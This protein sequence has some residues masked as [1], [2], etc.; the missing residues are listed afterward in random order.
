MQ[1]H[2]NSYKVTEKRNLMHYSRIAYTLLFSILSIAAANGQNPLPVV[3]KG[4]AT[5]A[6]AACSD[7]FAGNVNFA[8]FIGQSNDIW[9]TGAPSPDTIFLCADDHFDLAITGQNLTGDPDMST[10]AGVGYALYNCPPTISGPDK[11]TVG[12]DCHYMGATDFLVSTGGVTTGIQTFTNTGNLQGLLNSG[13]PVCVWF[14]PIT[15]DALNGNT[16]VY[17]NGGP[18]VNVNVSDAFP[19]VYL[20]QIQISDIQNT[21]G[22]FGC[23]GSFIV[24]GGLPEYISGEHYQIDISLVSDPS[25]KAILLKDSYSDGDLVR[26]QVNTAGLYNIRVRDGKSCDATATV[27]MPG[28]PTISLDLPDTTGQQ[29]TKICVPLTA[30]NFT[31]INGL[32]FTINWDSTVL[33][34][35]NIT[36]SLPDFDVSSYNQLNGGQVVVVWLTFSGVNIPDGDPVMEICFDLTGPPGGSTPIWLGPN[37]NGIAISDINGNQYGLL[38]KPGSIAIVNPNALSV[39]LDST[40]ALCAGDAT[41]SIDITV[42]AGAAFPISVDYDNNGGNP[43]GTVNITT[44]GQ[45]TTINNLTAGTYNLHFTDNNGGVLDTTIQV[46]D[47][48]TL[49][50]GLPTPTGTGL[51]YGESMQICPIVSVNGTQVNDLSGYS[52]VWSNGHTTQCIDTVPNGFFAVTVTDPDGC[53]ASASGVLTQKPPIVLNTTITQPTCSGVSNGVIDVQFSGGTSATGDYS[54]QWQHLPGSNMAASSQIFNLAPGT[55]YITVTDDDGCTASDSFTLAYEKEISLMATAQS[56]SCYGSQDG[57]ITASAH[58]IGGTE[59]LPYTF[60]WSPAVTNTSNPNPND[61]VA[62]DL[63][64]GTY[65]I[66]VSDADGCVDTTTAEVTEPDSITIVLDSIRHE[67]CGTGGDGLIAITATGGAGGITYAWN[68]TPPQNTNIIGGLAS[69]TYTVTVTDINGCTR[70]TNF[71]VNPPTPPVITGFNKTDVTCPT[72][73]DGTM[74]PVVTPGNGTNLSFSWNQG[75]NTPSISGLQTG[76]YSVTIADEY[77]CTA[78]ASDS[79]VATDG[80]FIASDT[81]IRPTCPGFAD[82]S[83]ILTVAGSG[84]YS[85]NWD[86]GTSTTNTLSG[87]TAGTYNVTVVD[88]Q[89][90]CPPLTGTYTLPD[91]PHIVPVTT[92]IQGASCYDGSFLDGSAQTTA[93]YSDST[94]GTFTFT[95]QP[96]FYQCQNTDNCTVT[97]LGPGQAILTVDDGTCSV[98]DTI[99]VPAP[100]SIKIDYTTTPAS[101]YHSTDGGATAIATG[102]T[103]GTNPDYTYSWTPGGQ[104]GPNLT[105]VPAGNYTVSVTDGVGCSATFDIVIDEPDSLE[106]LVDLTKTVDVYCYGDSTGQIV[107]QA[108]GGNG[109]YSFDWSPDISNTNIASL[110]PAGDYSV[111]VTDQKGCTQ[112][113]D[114]TLSQNEP[115]VASLNPVEPPECFGYQT[116]ISIDTVYGGAGGPYTYSVDYS[117][118][119]SIELEYQVFADSHYVLVYDAFECSTA[120][121]VNITEPEEIFLNLPEVVTVELGDSVQL[122]PIYSSQLP[123]DSFYWTPTNYLSDSSL[124]Q[125]FVVGLDQD[126]VFELTLVDANG[127]TQTAAVQVELDRNRNVY[128]PNVFSPNHDGFNDVFF[129]K[130]GIGVKEVNFMNIYDRWGELIYSAE[131]FLP[132]DNS[133]QYWDGTFRGKALHPGVFVYLIQV[134]F[135]DG[136]KLLYRG[137]VT[138]IR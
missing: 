84:N 79:I 119:Q 60:T 114:Y 75:Q 4:P 129:P 65:Q 76:I 73:N 33:S 106:L 93:A 61:E 3:S 107:V 27:N 52:F 23:K 117:P 121:S 98:N 88:N 48:K 15:F 11:A 94:S 132:R 45:M 78:T 118:P 58:N 2:L 92:L 83:I 9:N 20:N 86:T 71:T 110:L 36:S 89:S 12:G 8:N 26:F 95:W 14:A 49:G 53:Q 74:E 105:N 40:A 62:S 29:G 25:V 69:G 32:E 113:L 77:G 70:E 96:N 115:I 68:T 1:E 80:F 10:P 21:I 31:D 50:A 46:L 123:I 72:D 43:M 128:I 41:G 24:Q 6:R 56:I 64:A 91:P 44:A 99:I 39:T 97:N 136:R 18:C 22:G 5:A 120:L 34:F 102:G 90:A 19:V 87:V 59:A 122:I 82:G 127:C 55:Y 67:S 54:F 85:F 17:E 100:D 51:C 104:T 135:L 138:L 57:Q 137:D 38:D 101:C 131:H 130:T 30:G 133:T 35:S 16:A 13:N 112:S 7:Q 66:I 109:V 124:L 125:P 103:P 111:T 134:E 37:V 42:G 116:T 81:F 47:G 28:C 108:V 63:A 126:Q